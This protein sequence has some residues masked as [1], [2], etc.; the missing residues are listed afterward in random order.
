VSRQVWALI[1]L[2]LLTGARAGELVGMRPI[3]L[4]TSGRIWMFSPQE[5]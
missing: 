3:D 2:Q 4:D 1:Q 5:H